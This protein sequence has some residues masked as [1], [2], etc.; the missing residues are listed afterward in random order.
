[1]GLGICER[2]RAVFSLS[3]S[4]WNGSWKTTS[5]IIIPPNA[6]KEFKTLIQFIEENTE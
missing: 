3:E 1:M 5:N 2:E 6:L 4:R